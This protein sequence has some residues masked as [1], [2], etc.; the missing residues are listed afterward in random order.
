MALEDAEDLK[1]SEV[2]ELLREYQRVGRVLEGL[3]V[4]GE[5]EAEMARNEEIKEEPSGDGVRMGSS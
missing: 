5:E 3:R 1:M 2:R 4:V